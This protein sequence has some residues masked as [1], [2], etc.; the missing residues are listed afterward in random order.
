MRGNKTSSGPTSN[1][2]QPKIGLAEKMRGP[3]KRAALKM[4]T[5]SRLRARR[6]RREAKLEKKKPR[7]TARRAARLP[8]HRTHEGTLLNSHYGF[9]CLA[10]RAVAKAES[11]TVEVVYCMPSS[12][13]GVIQ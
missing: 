1:W 10:F 11:G 8:L 6:E 5:T 3:L 4:A 13:R 12:R 9:L 2:V 7:E